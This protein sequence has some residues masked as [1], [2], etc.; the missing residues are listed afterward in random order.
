MKF[1][2]GD[3]VKFLNEK[4]GGVIS[5]IISPSLVH[6]AIEDGFEIPVVPAELVLDE[7]EKAGE[8]RPIFVP[9]PTEE[10]I[11]PPLDEEETDSSKSAIRKLGFRGELADG[12][13]LAWVPQDQRWLITGLIDIYLVN[14]TGYEVLYSVVLH[15]AEGTYDGIDYDVLEPRTKILL[16][17][18]EREDIETWTDGV[19]QL[20]F[21]SDKMQSLLMPANAV[22][23]IKPARIYKEGN[24]KETPILDE[25]AF[26]ISLVEMN[27]H[28]VY[29]RSIKDKKFEAQ[30]HVGRKP[31]V[32]KEKAFIEKHAT[33]EGEAVV[34]LHIGELVNNIT[35]LSGH[36]MLKLQKD[37]F[38][39]ALESAIAENY[40]RVT[41]IHGVGNGVL[42]DEL[43]RLLKE[44]ENMEDQPASL[45][46][47]GVGAID[48]LIKNE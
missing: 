39:K 1:K 38:V 48:V 9:G 43:A 13:Y 2:V 41:F 10:I 36:D 18:I 29:S 6:V 42:R 11:L 44:Y 7:A 37:Y 27:I 46:K 24:Y 4:G 12:I 25:K 31:H 8:T 34:D 30:E 26:V 14:Y 23:D 45:A 17:T 21:H 35:G 32:K 15:N 20:L 3:R 5:K 19:I 16:D 28:P 47:Y 22:F 40:S 33:A